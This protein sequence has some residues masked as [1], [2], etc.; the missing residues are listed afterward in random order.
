MLQQNCFKGKSAGKNETRTPFASK[1]E[2]KT[3]LLQSKLGAKDGGRKCRKYHVQKKEVQAQED[4]KSDNSFKAEENEN[5]LLNLHPIQIHHKARNS[6]EK[7]LREEKGLSKHFEAEMSEHGL[8]DKIASIQYLNSYLGTEIGGGK[9]SGSAQGVSRQEFETCPAAKNFVFPFHKRTRSNSPPKNGQLF[10]PKNYPAQGPIVGN[11]V[12]A[13][14]TFQSKQTS[15]GLSTGPTNDEGHTKKD[16]GKL[17][18]ADDWM[19]QRLDAP[20]KDGQLLSMDKDQD[21]LSLVNQLDMSCDND[22]DGV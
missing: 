19:Y 14:R 6:R 5:E 22:L 21:F 3:A 12:V 18:L 20:Q 11:F 15:D 17:I 1:S 7:L 4:S 16:K 8:L 2:L 10:S 13:K 9:R